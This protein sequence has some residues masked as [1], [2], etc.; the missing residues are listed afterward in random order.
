[1]A[2]TLSFL[3]LAQRL[4]RGDPEAAAILFYRYAHRLIGLARRRLNAGVGPR[5]DADDVVNSVVRTFCRRHAERPFDLDGEDS[6]WALLAE[7]T[8]RKCNRWNRYFHTRKRDVRREHAPAASDDSSVDEPLGPSAPSPEDAAIFNDLLEQLLS[9]LDARTRRVCEMRL[10]GY[11]IKEMAAE[12][13]CTE[14]T[15]FRKLQRIK[16]RLQQLCP[17]E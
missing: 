1:M 16:E 6:L 17:P 11:Q 4:E 12:L 10:Q 9:G 13:D 14:T 8:L 3:D 7:I 15:V 2:I 5:V